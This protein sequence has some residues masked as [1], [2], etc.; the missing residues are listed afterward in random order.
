[1]AIK[2]RKLGKKQQ[3]RLSECFVLQVTVCSAADQLGMQANTMM[4]F[5]RNVRRVIAGKFAGTLPEHDEFQAGESYF[6]G[7]HKGKRGRGAAGN[8]RSSASSTRRQRLT[9]VNG[10]AHGNA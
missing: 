4:S 6:G 9:R 5:Y 3:L 2:L 10:V 8:D 7:V 1:M